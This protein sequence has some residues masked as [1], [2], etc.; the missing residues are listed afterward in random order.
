M[1]SWRDFQLHETKTM[2]KTL[3][4][5]AVAM[6]GSAAFSL[7]VA[8]TPGEM[9]VN[10]GFEAGDTSS[11]QYFNTP[12]STFN[13]SD[14][15]NG[16]AFAA[17]LFNNDPASGAVVKQA[18][19]GLGV[20]K[21]GDVIQ[22]SFAAKGSFAVGGV[23]FAE[24]FSEIVGGG[25]SKNEILGGGPLNLTDQWQT[26]CYTLVAG[27][28]VSGGV[29]LQF[30]A[31]TGGASGSTAVLFIDDASVSTGELTLNGGFEFGDTSSWVYFNTPNS[32]FSV[33]GDSNSGMFAAEL[34]N[35]DPASGAVIKQAN[36]GV[37]GV[38]P[39]DTINISFAAKGSFAAGGVAFAEFFSEIAGGGTSKN[40]ILGGGPLPLT[41]SYQTFNFTTTA[42]PDV[43]GGVTLQFAAVTGGDPAS[44][45]VL[46]VDD[47]SVVVSVGGGSANYCVA[48]TNND[49]EECSISIN[50]SSSLAA[51]DLELVATG[52]SSKSQ[53]GLFVFGDVQDQVPFGQG[54]L[55]VSL[56]GQFYRLNPVEAYSNV[57]VVTRL[58][59]NTV[60]PA[61]NIGA[62]ETWYFQ[63]L[64]RD[65]GVTNASDGIGVCF[66]P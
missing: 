43:S 53:F 28:D 52:V 36:L 65:M 23:A 27:P 40:E 55:C 42:G 8:D 49:G 10:G 30:A 26:F 33:T 47:A 12:N 62:G 38:K 5:A 32:T 9:T 13:V 3:L 24:F 22:V 46:F 16:G 66:L 31:V 15:A 64:Y 63:F 61:N 45:A 17:E 59:D 54:N 48:G 19:I 58:V 6:F 34:F 37:D 18:N 39:G 57:D 11:W 7:A 20:V 50:G 44:T 56:S 4:N 25:T 35:D 2:N 1:H 14:D 51:N 60:A 29:T 21:P 41:T